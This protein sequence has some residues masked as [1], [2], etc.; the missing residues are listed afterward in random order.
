M[1]QHVHEALDE[2]SRSLTRLQDDTTTLAVIEAAAQALIATF[3]NGGHVFSCGNPQ[4][5][6]A[7]MGALTLMSM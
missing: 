3:S 7:R 6:Y 4:P 5:G 2:S 1:R